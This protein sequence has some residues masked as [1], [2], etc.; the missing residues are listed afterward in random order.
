MTESNVAV[1]GIHLGDSQQRVIALFGQPDETSFT[2][3]TPF[4]EWYYAKDNMYVDFYATGAWDSTGGMEWIQMIL[5]RKPFRSF[6]GY[7]I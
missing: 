3:G 7:P 1:G 6:G 2:H 5:V 4:P